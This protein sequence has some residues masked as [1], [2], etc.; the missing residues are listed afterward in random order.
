MSASKHLS[1]S[2]FHT[3]PHLK[4]LTKKQKGHHAEANFSHRKSLVGYRPETKLGATQKHPGGLHAPKT[5]YKRT[6]NPST[7]VLHTPKSRVYKNV[8]K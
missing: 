4:R 1:H 8:K 2:Q 3:V 5:N 7:Y 6:L